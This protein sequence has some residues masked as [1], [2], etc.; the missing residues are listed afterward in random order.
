MKK[1]QI[2]RHARLYVLIDAG[3]VGK[4]D[5]IRVAKQIASG[6]ADLVQYRHKISDDGKF[7]Q[8][9]LELKKIFKHK[10]IPLIINDRLDIAYCIDADGVHLGQKDLP[11]AAAR[12]LLGK[13]KIIGASA[14]TENQAKSAQREGAD[15]IGLGPIFHTTT[16]K[17]E[18]VRGLNLLR[19]I[20][21]SLKIP[22][23]AI[24]GINLQNL[25]QI[26]QAECQRI[27]VGSAILNS[28]NP[29]EACRKF[30]RRMR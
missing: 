24:G 16:K 21:G 2:L 3:L 6:G 14:E 11:V 4:R 12:K 9:A 23:F 15:Y 8:K 30:S 27:V 17:I 20:K 25:N 26:T 7:L 13:S 10:G 5:L 19:Q 28:R 1:R 22:Y 29:R 18:K